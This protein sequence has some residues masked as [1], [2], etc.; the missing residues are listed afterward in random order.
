MSSGLRLYRVDKV[1]AN[2]WR[3]GLLAILCLAISL[4]WFNAW[5]TKHEAVSVVAVEL[6][7][8]QVE[9][10]AANKELEEF[11]AKEAARVKKLKGVADFI[12][13]VNPKVGQAK[14]LKQAEYEIFFA[15]YFNVDLP[16]S[17][18][19]SYRETHFTC[20]I[21]SWDLSSYGCKQINLEA[22][23]SYYSNLNLSKQ[24]LFDPK[25]NIALGNHMLAMH[26]DEYNGNLSRAIERYRG[27][28]RPSTNEEYRQDVFAKAKYIRKYLNRVL[29]A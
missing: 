25:F 22:W 21:V 3:V 12:Q 26:I 2:K 1:N 24:K 29:T 10:E 5:S 9:L 19:I 18:A 27:S 13:Q 7:K 4:N 15:D 11:K 6:D 20:D 23:K 8:A 17:L 28:V 16:T 14:A